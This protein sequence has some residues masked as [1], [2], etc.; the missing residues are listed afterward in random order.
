MKLSDIEKAAQE[1]SGL[2]DNPKDTNSR[3]KGLI[4]IAFKDGARWH[5]ENIW[6]SG[7]VAVSEFGVYLVEYE[8]DEIFKYDLATCGGKSIGLLGDIKHKK[9][10]RW[11]RLYDLLPIN[12]H[13]RIYY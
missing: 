12:K 9:I 6:H 8:E 7:E 10:T 1:Y 3:E 4:C 5:S 13:N 2:T 11:A